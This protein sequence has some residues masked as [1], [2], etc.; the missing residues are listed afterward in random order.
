MFSNMASRFDEL[1]GNVK[2]ALTIFVAAGGFALM[3]AL[4]KL[5]GQRLEVTQIL[6]VR[7]CIMMMIVMPKVC[8]SVFRYHIRYFHFA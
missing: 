5:V 2:G 8:E 4:I 6:L 7:Q 3:T 1:P